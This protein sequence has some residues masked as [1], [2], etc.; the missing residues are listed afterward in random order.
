MF[1]QIRPVS[2]DELSQGGAVLV[3]KIDNYSVT[4]DAP[5]GRREFQFDKVFCAKASQ[6]ELFHDTGES[7]YASKSGTNTVYSQMYHIS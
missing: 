2:R 4:V 1:C 7:K 6:E 3:E 5:Q